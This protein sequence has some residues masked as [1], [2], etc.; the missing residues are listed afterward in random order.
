MIF[1]LLNVE[2][3]NSDCIYHNRIVYFLNIGSFCFINGIFFDEGNSL[4]ESYRVIATSSRY[5]DTF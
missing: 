4:M 1:N 3:P 5:K 2:M